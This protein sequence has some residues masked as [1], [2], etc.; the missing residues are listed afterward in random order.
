MIN[1]AMVKRESYFCIYL[2]A[3]HLNASV[4]KCVSVCVYVLGCVL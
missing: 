3:C 2:F 1:D 4:Y